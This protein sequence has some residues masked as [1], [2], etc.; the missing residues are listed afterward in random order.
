MSISQLVI[1]VD[2]IKL[3]LVL[4]IFM[5]DIVNLTYLLNDIIGKQN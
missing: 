5:H 1:L 4:Q 2:R 3:K